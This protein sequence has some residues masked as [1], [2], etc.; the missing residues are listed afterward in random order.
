MKKTAFTVL[1]CLLML[2]C[3]CAK[4]DIGSAVYRMDSSRLYSETEIRQAMDTA[5]GHFRAEFEG[6]TLLTM[7]YCEDSTAAA[8]AEWADSLGADQAMILLSSFRVDETGGD[9]SLT[10]LKTY[11]NWQWVLVRSEGEAWK[12]H[13]WG[14]G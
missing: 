8:A 6:C 9:G 1:I 3:G 14:Y 10:P 13:T 4:G 11:H 2:L 5:A 12:L 7:D